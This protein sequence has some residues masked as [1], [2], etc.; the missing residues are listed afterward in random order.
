M[1]DS[2][3]PKPW[4]A[5]KPGRYRLLVDVFTEKGVQSYEHLFEVMEPSLEK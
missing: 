5:E 1:S 3:E 4:K 2:F